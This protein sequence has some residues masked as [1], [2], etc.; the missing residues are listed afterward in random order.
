MNL[1]D[2]IS[3]SA[4]EQ[5][6]RY[7]PTG[8]L[9]ARA[10]RLRRQRASRRVAVTAVAAGVVMLGGA[11]L[12]TD[13]LGGSGRNVPAAQPTPPAAVDTTE[14]AATVDSE[15]PT[16]TTA[17][18]DPASTSTTAPATVATPPPTTLHPATPPAQAS[19]GDPVWTF[20]EFWNVPQLGDENR[21]RGTGCG[22]SKA[23]PDV[24]PDGLWAAYITGNDDA[25][26]GIDLLCIYA[27][28][29]AAALPNPDAT[30]VVDQP[31]Y[32]I[33]NN[34]ARARAMPMDPGIVLRLGVRTDEGTCL[35]GIAADQWADIPPDRQVWVRIHEGRVTWVFAD[36][37]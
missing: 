24:I 1:E 13:P 18:T 37:E 30:V 20:G 27:V 25:H 16:T 12:L 23:I 3:S 8:D 36:C 21:V 4:G 7:R 32:V 10:G 34:Q 19:A 9:I 35:D 2:L 5:A 6:K 33:V 22:S 31:D 17:T 15:A 14:A 28:P 29:S 26:V 11:L